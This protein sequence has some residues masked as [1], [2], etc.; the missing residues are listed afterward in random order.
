M[1]ALAPH[2]SRRW[3]VFAFLSGCYS[4]NEPPGNPGGHGAADTSGAP[5]S[6]SN[7]APETGTSG[8][9]TG[10]SDS[11]DGSGGATTTTVGGLDESSTGEPSCD[12]TPL[13]CPSGA[14]C[15]NGSCTAPPEGMVA[16]PAGPFMM[17]C[18]EQVD[19]QCLDD[20]YP[21]HEV[22]LSSFAI[23]R[24]EVT[25]EAYAGCVSAGDCSPPALTFGDRQPCANTSGQQPVACVDWFQARDFCASIG[26]RLP[27]EAEWEKAAR[28]TDGRMFPWGNDAPDCSRAHLA[29]PCPFSAEPLVV[30]S[31][32][33]GASPYGALDMAGNLFEWVSD[34]YGVA[35]YVSSPAEDPP[36]PAT[37]TRRS[38]RS[39]SSS[40]GLEYGSR[41]SLRGPD[42]LVATPDDTSDWIGFRC[43]RTP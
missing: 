12:D 9:A 7:G 30:G 22:T 31:K 16:V 37:G 20:E 40:F 38:L 11:S 4:P 3:P 15:V 42:Y 6:T 43:A 32:P 27:T 10:S 23:D 8:P 29:D 39:S 35:Y 36:G 17:G 1:L 33:A 34:W 24:T 21:Y 18:N 41:V 19:T 14:Y 2:S 5:A 26:K 25:A 28:G 13:S